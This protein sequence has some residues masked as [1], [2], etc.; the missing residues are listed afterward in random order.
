MEFTPNLAIIRLSIAEFM[1]RI[2]L[3]LVGIFAIFG[4]L[5]AQNLVPNPSFETYTGCPGGNSAISNGLVANWNRPPGSIITPDLFTPCTSS[6]SSCTD[7]NTANHCVGSS[8]AFHA[9][10]YAGMLWYYTGCPNCKEYVVAQ[11]T[12]FC[13]SGTVYRASYRAKLGPLCRYGTNHLGL[14]I[15]AAAPN[16]PGG[17]QPIL[18]TPTV[19]R[20]GQVLDKVNWTLISGTF[21]SL[22]TERYITMGNFY[23]DAATAIFDFGSSAGSCIFATGAA[24]YMFDS[25]N[26][27]PAVILPVAV[28]HFAGATKANGNQLSW[29]IAPQTALGELWLDHST[30]GDHFNTI[31]HWRNPAEKE[32]NADYLHESAAQ[33]VHFYRLGMADRNGEFMVSEVVTLRNRE[34]EMIR[35]QLQPNPSDQEASLHF[36]LPEHADAYSLKVSALNGAVVW[37]EDV[38][39]APMVAEHRLSTADLQAGVYVVEVSS[40]G[41]K[42]FQRLVVVH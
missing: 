15:S 38:R 23:N 9:T 27:R 16:Q 42:G 40:A 20:P 14:Y 5:E 17:N 11:L 25:V 18:I 30:D 37:Q 13:T 28:E 36:Q 35:L 2:L 41:L 22:G 31:A 6:G 26:V 1:K 12:S 4:L 10:A 33:G 34:P 24:Y 7:F 8:P 32:L 21:T 29:E 19:E 3:T 39:D